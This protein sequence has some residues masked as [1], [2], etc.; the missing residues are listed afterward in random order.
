MRNHNVLNDPYLVH[1]YKDFVTELSL[2]VQHFSELIRKHQQ[3]NLHCKNLKVLYIEHSREKV[4]I[5]AI[6]EF[7]KQNAQIE[8]F[9]LQ[10]MRMASIKIVKLLWKQ[11]ENHLHNV[12]AIELCAWMFQ[13]E[14]IKSFVKNNT[15][16][17][18]VWCMTNKLNEI[19]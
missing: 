7:V 2:S 17:K 16:I 4:D 12:K 15:N 5:D 14:D 18:F 9:S 19:R 8:Y 10:K 3:T 6:A 1:Q 11:I 13:V